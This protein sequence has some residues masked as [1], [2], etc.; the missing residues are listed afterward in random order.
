MSFA[1]AR[2]AKAKKPKTPKPPKPKRPPSPPPADG[3]KRPTGRPSLYT[4]ELADELCVRIARRERL[5]TILADPH[6]PCQDTIYHWRQTKP[7]FSEKLARAREIRGEMRVA[8]VDDLVADVL[9]GKL[10]PNVGRVA[11]IAEQ[12]AASR[13]APKAYGDRVSADVTS[14]GKPLQAVDASAAINA[15][16]A[17]LP[18][19]APAALPAPEPLEAEAVSVEEG[20]A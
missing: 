6:M 14:D 20:E 19:L 10:D 12:W 9:A 4:E 13:E 3:S 5:S 7:G 2:A 15:L 8:M 1:S 11:I 16:L 18:S 17:A